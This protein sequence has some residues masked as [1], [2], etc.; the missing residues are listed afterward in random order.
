MS[1]RLGRSLA[2][3]TLACRSPY[4]EERKV[5]SAAAEPSRETVAGLPVG[6]VGDSASAGAAKA[7]RRRGEDAGGIRARF[8]RRMLG[9]IMV[10]TGMLSERQR[11]RVL[12][13]QL[14]SRLPFGEL[15]RRMRLVSRDELERALGLQFGFLHPLTGAGRFSNDLVMLHRPFGEYAEAVR[16]AARR[17]LAQWATRERNALAITSPGRGEGRS[18]FAANLAMAFAQMGCRTLLLDADLRA[19]RQ[20]EIFGQPAH[21]GLSRLLCGYAADDVAS[22]VA[23]LRNLTLISAGPCP[24]DPLGLLGGRQ[25]ANLIQRAREHYDMVVVDTPAAGRH[26][27]AEIVAAATGSALLLAAPNRSR[28]EPLKTL[29]RDLRRAEVCVAGSLMNAC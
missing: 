4:R 10:T 12:K 8:A 20:H 21:P 2:P 18:H 16:S 25:F 14:R 29:V 6:P 15:S 3:A 1:R 22:G 11:D 28:L 27:D 13:R 23:G 19:P 9:E 24:P 26:L 7:V 17:L 5:N